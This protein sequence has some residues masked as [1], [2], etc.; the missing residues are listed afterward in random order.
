MRSA[1]RAFR[2]QVEKIIQELNQ[3]LIRQ[4]VGQ[5]LA[6]PIEAA[7]DGTTFRSQASH[8]RTFNHE[9]LGKRKAKLAAAVAAD[10]A[11]E[12]PPAP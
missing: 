4:G 10:D 6:A 1:W 7:Q 9:T 8:H 11:Q 2:D 5:G 3:K 12:P